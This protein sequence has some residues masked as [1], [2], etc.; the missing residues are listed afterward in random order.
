MSAPRQA[1]EH[2]PGFLPLGDLAAHRSVNAWHL[3][4]P[5]DAHSALAAERQTKRE[6]DESVERTFESSLE[7]STAVTLTE[8]AP[9]PRRV[10]P[11]HVRIFRSEAL[12]QANANLQAADRDQTKYARPLLERASDNDG[13]RALPRIR[14]AQKKLENAQELF[15]NLREPIQKLKIDLTLASA[16]RT[17]DFRIRPILLTGQPGVGKTHFALRMADAL[18]VPM[19]KW[20]A[21]SAQAS[22]Q[23]TGGDSGWRHARPGMVIELLAK[24]SAAAPI[25]VLDE[26]DKISSGSSYPVL[27]V[28]LDLLE[29]ETARKF[30]DTFFRMEF[31]ASRIVFVLTANDVRAVPAPLL[32]RAEV[33]DIPAPQPEQRLQIIQAEVERL[34]RTTRKRIELDVHAALALAERVDLDLRQTHRLVADAFAT[35]LAAGQRVAVPM[36]PVRTGR[37]SIGFVTGA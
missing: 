22:F 7:D 6:L 13:Y 4:I 27:P 5:S 1:T 14:S 9:V 19:R 8:V 18:G 30:E 24:S 31:D 17:N 28:L 16:M 35:A 23:L 10:R 33:F 26:V 32:S 2:P 15:A 25:L 36:V 12:E 21:G 11:R 37:R 29:G 20:A 34:R 3:L